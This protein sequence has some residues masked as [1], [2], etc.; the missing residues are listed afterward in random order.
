MA[1][2][3]AGGGAAAAG[4]TTAAGGSS[5]AAAAGK[6]GSAS[7][8][9]VHLQGRRP[10][11]SRSASHF[12]CS[13][14]WLGSIWD[15][16]EK[17]FICTSRSPGPRLTHAHSKSPMRSGKGCNTRLSSASRTLL[18]GPSTTRSITLNGISIVCR[19]LE[20][21]AVRRRLSKTHVGH[22][23]NDQPLR[24]H[25]VPDHER[26]NAV[27]AVRRSQVAEFEVTFRELSSA[28][29]TTSISSGL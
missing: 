4:A 15:P 6:C 9:A 10:G 11:A 19:T 14:S 1:G 5:L 3:S 17:N 13:D 21:P 20:P 24:Q 18:G 16:G 7:A 12:C 23:T 29:L 26:A 2:S 22:S 8:V 28:A 27:L 25:V